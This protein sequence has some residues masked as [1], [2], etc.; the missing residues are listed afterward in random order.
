MLVMDLNMVVNGKEEREDVKTTQLGVSFI[1]KRSS[2]KKNPF[3]DWI[4]LAEKLITVP[5]IQIK[6]FELRP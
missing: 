3:Y 2:F 6:Y 5:G 4:N 1:I